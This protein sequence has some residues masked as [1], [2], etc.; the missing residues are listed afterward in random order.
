VK[1]LL[2]ATMLIAIAED[3]DAYVSK[4]KQTTERLVKKRFLLLKD[5]AKIIAG[6]KKADIP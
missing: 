6:A 3:H 2:Q 1:F 4:V 5:A